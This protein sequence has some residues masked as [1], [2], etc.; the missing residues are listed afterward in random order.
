LLP[1]TPIS[2]AARSPIR[3]AIYASISPKDIPM[4]T[5]REITK[6]RKIFEISAFLRAN[7]YHD[8]ASYLQPDS[9]VEPT[10]IVTPQNTPEISIWPPG[11][12]SQS[13][14]PKFFVDVDESADSEAIDAANTPKHPMQLS[15]SHLSN[16]LHHL[17]KPAHVNREWPIRRLSASKST[18]V[19]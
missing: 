4:F 2:I 5:K 17:R 6:K 10:R 11:E 18:S 9:D 13:A 15:A 14:M 7:D 12:A 19:Y 1:V 3:D 8:P 16:Y